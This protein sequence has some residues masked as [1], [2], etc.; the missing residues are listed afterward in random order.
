MTSQQ[1]VPTKTPVRT[2]PDTKPEVVPRIEPAKI[3][4]AQK[5]KIRRKI[6]DEP[7]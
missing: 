4:P 5:E 2:S 7:L 3:C 1:P 6:E